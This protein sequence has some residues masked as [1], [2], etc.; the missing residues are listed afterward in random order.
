MKNIVVTT[1][2]LIMFFGF[3]IYSS[4]NQELSAHKILKVEQADMYYIDLNNNNIIDD[5]ELI[6]LQDVNAF[7]PLKNDFSEKQALKLNLSIE[8][9][10]KLGFLSKLWAKEELT[11]KTVYLDLKNI[12]RAVDKK[13]GYSYIKYKNKD[14]G[15]TLLEYG[16]G[17]VYKDIQ[18]KNYYAVNNYS[19]IRR[20]LENLSKWDFV[21][22]NLKTGVVHNLSCEHTKSLHSGLLLLKTEIQGYSPCKICFNKQPLS[23]K[24]E[25]NIPKSINTYKKS[26]YKKF[27]NIELF[28][29]N[30]LEFKKPNKG[31]NTQIC[32]RIVQEIDSSKISI[33]IALYGVGEQMEIIN[34]LKRARSRGVE[35]R[36]VVDFSKDM[37]NIYP[38]TSKFIEEF[39]SKTD[40][41]SVLMHNKFFIFDN[42][43]VLTGSTNISPSGTGG[44]N[45]NSSVLVDSKEIANAYKKEF[46]QMYGGKFSNKKAKNDI[47]I[48]SNISVYFSPKNNVYNEVIEKEVRNAKKEIF[49]SIFYL[50]DRNLINELVQAKNRGVEVL[51]LL[52][53]LCAN[54]FKDRVYSLRDAK[55]PVIVENWGGKNHEKTMV[56]DSSTLLIG[57]SNFSKSGFYKNDENILLIK[58]SQVASFYRDYY[59]Y[60]FNS[61]DRKFL[62]LIPRAE[63]IDSVNSCFDGVDNNFDGKI[64]MDD[65]GCKVQ[66]KKKM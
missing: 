8:D 29:I 15:L 10:M 35:I 16:L 46:E 60:L 58:D 56:I 12:K 62:K 39:S 27:N 25:F 23:F 51:V 20:N 32:K 44:Y 63:G 22:L 64:D 1:I 28:L 4:K 17:F 7:Y 54:G 14:L 33:D 53:A 61:I 24:D 57:S 52:D 42:K 55:I 19:Q 48:N 31:C 65:D 5:N 59:L 18:D 13:Y 49:I 47:I 2:L 21:V 41:P 43:K 66:N 40:K 45:A 26:V 30:P 34:A 50:T 37:D 3:L 6:K 9:Y 38:Y 11:D 36:S